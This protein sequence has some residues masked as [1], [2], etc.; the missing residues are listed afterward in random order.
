MRALSWIALTVLTACSDRVTAKADAGADADAG[1][2]F[3]QGKELVLQVPAFV[4]L[5]PLSV[6]TIADPK[7]SKDWDLQFTGWDVFTN[8]G[9]SGSGMCKAFG[10]LDLDVFFETQVP[11]VPFLYT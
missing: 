10:P 7:T 6:V 5:D 3:D 11:D 4:K 9:L 8:S 2:P 1:S